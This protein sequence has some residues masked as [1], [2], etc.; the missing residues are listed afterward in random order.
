VIV[1]ELVAPLWPAFAGALVGEAFRRW[2]GA[3]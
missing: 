3:K 1:L 2:L